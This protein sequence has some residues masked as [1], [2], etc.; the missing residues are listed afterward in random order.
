MNVHGVYLQLL[1]VCLL[2]WT[3]LVYSKS[4]SL[5]VF[6]E[7]PVVP[8]G[9]DIVLNCS[10][11]CVNYTS[12]DWETSVRKNLSR[13]AQ[14]VA[15]YIANQTAWTLTPQCYLTQSDGSTVF[16]SVNILFYTFSPPKIH[17]RD[18]IVAGRE[19]KVTC[20][21]SSMVAGATPPNVELTLSG[22]GKV[23]AR[24]QNLVLEYVFTA[25]ANHDGMALVC[26]ARLQVANTTLRK[27]ETVSM[28]VFYQPTNTSVL[29][30]RRTFQLGQNFTVRCR[31]AGNPVP[32]FTWR[33]PSNESV[34]VAS[35]GKTVSVHSARVVHSGTYE[36]N[37]TNRYGVSTARAN[38]VEESASDSPKNVP[39]WAIAFIVL[40]LL[41]VIGVAAFL[42]RR[43]FI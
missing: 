23:L 35:D 34:E 8:Y 22:D 3:V 12:L 5:W 26:T 18:E 25:G 16:S 9:T 33:L 32:S 29:T 20:S 36:C 15:L 17:L 40:F 28:M 41:G 31:S 42:I 19:E 39:P 10:T 4:C 27:N 14:W 7:H 6:P 37:A 30:E 11:S 13:G 1:L 24:N 38:I 2:C 21:V 43:A